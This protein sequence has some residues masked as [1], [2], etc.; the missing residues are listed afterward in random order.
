MSKKKN[1]AM[2]NEVEKSDQKRTLEAARRW[3]DSVQD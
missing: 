2:K 3:K 1:T